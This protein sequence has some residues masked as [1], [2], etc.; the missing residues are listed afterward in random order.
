M[1][2]NLLK[3]RDQ[4]FKETVTLFI[5]SDIPR[6]ISTKDIDKGADGAEVSF[7]GGTL[8]LLIKEGMSSIESSMQWRS[9][10]I[11]LAVKTGS[12]RSWHIGDPSLAQFYNVT[13]AKLPNPQ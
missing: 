13:R 4:H 10:S 12:W 6:E 1:P 5:P 3:L 11:S 7:V 9:V 2:C 8:T